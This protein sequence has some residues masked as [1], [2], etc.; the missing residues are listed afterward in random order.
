MISSHREAWCRV[1]DL[2]SL[3]FFLLVNYPD[4]LLRVNI[5]INMMS[6]RTVLRAPW[7]AV[8]PAVGGMVTGSTMECSHLYQG[9]AGCMLHLTLFSR[10]LG[11]RHCILLQGTELS[12]SEPAVL[13]KEHL[14][15]FT[16]ACKFLC[17]AH[18][19]PC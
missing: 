6:L 15:V 8:P 3:A 19:L 12:A 11:T 9:R 18:L 7:A 13:R 1:C 4:N 2:A 10:D 17:L 16:Q 5:C 14:A